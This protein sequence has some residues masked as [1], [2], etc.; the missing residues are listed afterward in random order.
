MY[1][2]LNLKN[3]FRNLIEML[4]Y[5][6]NKLKFAKVQIHINNPS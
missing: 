6:I 1:A 2:S 5:K 3:K 4:Y